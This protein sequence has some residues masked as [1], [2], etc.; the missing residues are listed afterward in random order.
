MVDFCHALNCVREKFISVEYVRRQL[1]LKVE[2]N[3]E[4]SPTA[5]VSELIALVGD[6]TNLQS[7]EI[8]SLQLRMM[9]LDESK[10][11]WEQNKAELYTELERLEKLKQEEVKK[12]ED[13][14]SAK[15]AQFTNISSDLERTI[16]DLTDELEHSRVKMLHSTQDR[17]LL[18]ERA[19]SAE[20]ETQR[21]NKVKTVMVQ[22]ALGL[23]LRVEE[24][25]EEKRALS[26]MVESGL[27]RESFFKQELETMF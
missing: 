6:I 14:Y 17:Q 27:E 1:S 12:L 7:F 23:V 18:E 25:V 21:L 11:G 15:Y 24:L 2:A 8:K 10:Q 16:K 3:A 22:I 4:E 9:E 13:A 19:Q 5:A 20:E 26:K